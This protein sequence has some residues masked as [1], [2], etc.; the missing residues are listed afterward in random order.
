MW[1]VMLAAFE[2]RRSYRVQGRCAQGRGQGPYV[3]VG[4]GDAG[5]DH[6]K[7]RYEAEHRAAS[8]VEDEVCGGRGEARSRRAYC[9]GERKD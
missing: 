1:W 7:E 8:E 4:A 2:T 3:A 6:L 5:E 9:I